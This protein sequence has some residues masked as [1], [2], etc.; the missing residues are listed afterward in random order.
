MNKL[1][2][3]AVGGGLGSVLRYLAASWGQQLVAGEF[4]IGTL[5]V[6]VSGCLLIG[7]L[8]TLFVGP[9]V[10]REEYRIAVLVG[11]L[12]GFTTFSTFGYETWGLLADRSWGMAIANF[13]ISNVVGVTAVWLGQRLA[14]LH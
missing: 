8:G 1:L 5:L 3:I 9:A 10:L 2:L 7:Y 11:F 12:G 4:P 14:N 13:L 6:N